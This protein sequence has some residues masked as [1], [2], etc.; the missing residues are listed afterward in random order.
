MRR[1]QPAGLRRTSCTSARGLEGAAEGGGGSERV[2]QGA[3]PPGVYL[4]H[5]PVLP[6]QLVP[7]IICSN[8]KL[9]LVLLIICSVGPLLRRSEGD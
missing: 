7:R 2:R 4:A 8:G 9:I 3:A 5:L 1:R 6:G